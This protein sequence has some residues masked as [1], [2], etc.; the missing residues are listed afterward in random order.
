MHQQTFPHPAASRIACGCSRSVKN[1]ALPNQTVQVHRTTYVV[2]SVHRGIAIIGWDPRFDHAR[3]HVTECLPVSMEEHVAKKCTVRSGHCTAQYV[4]D[5]G[6]PERNDVMYCV[7][8]S[9]LPHDRNHHRF[10]RMLEFV[11]L[12]Q[13]DGHNFNWLFAISFHFGDS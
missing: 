12:G 11:I 5:E 1:K 7:V 10:C 2:V 3:F 4:P 8:P 6:K 9:L 13:C